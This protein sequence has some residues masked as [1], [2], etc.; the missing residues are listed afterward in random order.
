MQRVEARPAGGGAPVA[1]PPAAL[2]RA[3]RWTGLAAAALVV[4]LAAASALVHPAIG[5]LAMV[6]LLAAPVVLSSRTRAL[7]LL[8]GVVLLL[9][10]A[11]LPLNLGFNPTL[12]DFALAAVYLIWVMRRVT[13]ADEATVLTTPLGMAVALF[14]G[15]AGVAF[16]AGLAQGVPSKNQLRTFAELLLSAGLFI[17]ACDLVRDRGALRRL[18]R[19]LVGLGA[20][21][22][23][24]GLGLVLLPDTLQVRLL[25]LLRVLDYPT[26]PGVLRYL[27]DDPSRLQ[28][29]TGTSIDP[30]AFGGLLAVVLACLL[31]QLLSRDPVL[32]RRPAIAMATLMGLAV[33]ATVSRA[34]LLGL[35]AAALV[36]A[37]ARDRRLVLLILGGGTVALLVAAAL[38]WTGDYLAHLVAGLSGADRA[39][40]MR[41]GEYKDALRLIGRYPL[42]GVGFGD[43]GDADL[44]RG[45]SSLYLIV[46]SSMGLVGLGAFLALMAACA[47]HLTRAWRRLADAGWLRDLVLGSLAALVAVTVS[48]LFDHYFF[49]YPHE[50]ALLWLLVALGATAAR[51]AETPEPPPTS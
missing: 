42:L 49:T 21:A 6:A 50:M 40:Q 16:L 26:G 23:A 33:L 34:A 37:L 19:L 31:P 41:F 24:L 35:L 12:L 9:P 47:A 17:V 27:N 11:A 39:T 18:Y 38:P 3:R 25:S 36:V 5:V 10:F 1:G 8:I 51:L 4:L 44:Y 43:V 15:L 20:L 13:R 14:I 46:A 28:R 2:A 30:N 7:A 45:V 22:A 48:G 29:A 32:P